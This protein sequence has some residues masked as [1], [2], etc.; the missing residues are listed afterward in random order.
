MVESSLQF[1][2]P[3]QSPAAPLPVSPASSARRRRGPAQIGDQIGEVN[4]QILQLPHRIP[5]PFRR[6][7]VRFWD[8]RLRRLRLRIKLGVLVGITTK[9]FA[10]A[11]FDELAHRELPALVR[12]GTQAR[13]LLWVYA[14]GPGHL[15]LP[16]IRFADP[17]C[18]S[19]N[20]LIILSTLRRHVYTSHW[21]K[22]GFGKLSFPDQPP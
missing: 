17:L 2:A 3:P 1:R 7:Q 14:E 13:Q 21:P 6:V 12:A 9:S 10:V 5:R 16:G 11:G 18:I 4:D 8:G 20:F 19:P 15:G 22:L